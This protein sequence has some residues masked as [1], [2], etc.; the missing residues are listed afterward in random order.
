MNFFLEWILR[1]VNYIKFNKEIIWIYQ[2]YKKKTHIYDILHFFF[3]TNKENKKK[4]KRLI[5]DKMQIENVDIRIIKWPQQF[6]NK[7]YT[8]SC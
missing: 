6:Y 1:N 5:K 4:N 3:F 8:T 7:S 2:R